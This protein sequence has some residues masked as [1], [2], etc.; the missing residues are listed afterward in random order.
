[1]ELLHEF[2]NESAKHPDTVLT[3][4]GSNDF[5]LERKISVLLCR[6]GLRGS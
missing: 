5:L 1:M 4:S 3:I 2:R 6:A